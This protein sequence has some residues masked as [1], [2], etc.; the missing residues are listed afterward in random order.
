MLRYEI[1]E[2]KVYRHKSGKTAS[3]FGSCPYYYNSEKGDW[4][5]VGNGYSLHD[6]K[7]NIRFQPRGEKT[8]QG[9]IN[10]M[11][12]LRPGWKTETI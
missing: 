8:E 11:D 7:D 6:H 9:I 5:I 12:T 2:S 10:V 1:V 4:Q 3:I